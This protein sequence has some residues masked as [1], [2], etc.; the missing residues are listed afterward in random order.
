MSCLILIVRSLSQAFEAGTGS[1]SI[2]PGREKTGTG[3]RLR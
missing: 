3:P 1:E 2:E